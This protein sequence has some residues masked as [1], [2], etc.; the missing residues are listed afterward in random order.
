MCPTEPKSTDGRMGADFI[1][2]S[3]TDLNFVPVAAD[4]AVRHIF[5]AGFPN[6]PLE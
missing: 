6:D 1:R 5:T 3:L 4:N 2:K